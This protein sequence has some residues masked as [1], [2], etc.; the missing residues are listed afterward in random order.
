MG[1]WKKRA[2]EHPLFAASAPEGLHDLHNHILPGLD[3]GSQSLEESLEMADGL[4]R[5]G[6]VELVATPH[7]SSRKGQPGR[8]LQMARIR[9][10][11][12]RRREAPPHIRPGGEILFDEAFIEAEKQGLAPS[13]A[14]SPTYLVELGLG[15]AMVP[16]GAESAL[17]RIVMQ[18]KSLILAHPERC[19][20]FQR[21]LAR[22]ADMRAVGL[23]VQLDVMSLV[24]R[25]G[26]ASRETAYRILEEGLADVAATDIHRR[27]DLPMVEAALEALFDWDA[28]EFQRLFSRN[29]RRVLESRP[30]E[31]DRHG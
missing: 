11:A 9:Q 18:G 1:W 10:I 16:L 26:D 6:F 29:P 15:P 13:L 31:V 22:L 5:L 24:G 25:N 23:L 12:A 4:A 2:P 7:F 21:N 17:D 20:D 14:V 30:E 19:A 3:D 28:G 27:Q 8:E